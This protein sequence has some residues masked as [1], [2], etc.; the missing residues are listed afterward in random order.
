[1][2]STALNTFGVGEQNKILDWF[3]T[4]A[5]ELNVVIEKRVVLLKHKH[6]PVRA[7]FQALRTTR[8]DA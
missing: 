1:M 6:Q 8:N 7:S 5:N 2:D 3:E 4:S